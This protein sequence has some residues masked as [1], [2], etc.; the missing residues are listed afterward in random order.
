M[1]ILTVRYHSKNIHETFTIS[2]PTSISC[3][4]E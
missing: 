2:S 4:M 3:A 1:Y